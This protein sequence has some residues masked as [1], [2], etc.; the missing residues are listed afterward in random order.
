MSFY[1]LVDAVTF[2][3]SNPDS[4]FQQQDEEELDEAED[5]M[6]DSVGKICLNLFV[7]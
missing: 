2:A 5:Q 1:T 4:T 3:A 7:I 6:T